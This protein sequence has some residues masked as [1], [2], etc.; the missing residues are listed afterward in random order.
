MQGVAILPGPLQRLGMREPWRT[1]ADLSDKR[2]GA[3]A[4]IGGAAL[5]AL[6]PHPVAVASGGDLSPVDGHVQHLA[7]FLGNCYAR[8][9]PMWP[10]IRFAR[11]RWSSSPAR[12]H[13][14]GCPKATGRRWP[15]AGRLG[16]R[17]VLEQIRDGE[18]SARPQLCRQGIRFFQA[19]V[20][21]LR[22]AVEPVYTEMR[23]DA[24]AARV[25][26]AVEKL[27]SRKRVEPRSCPAEDRPAVG[28]PS[29]TYAWTITRAEALRVR[30]EEHDRDFLA[31]LPTRSGR[32]SDEV[33]SSSM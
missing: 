13:G 10:R 33:T 11:D 3:P 22:R 16:V 25:L 12:R 31:Q 15:K 5:K 28:L 20:A 8:T 21:D 19:D 17:S 27:R 2:I 30:G 1:A 6:G 14:S 29:G 7:A 4:G 9:I 26:D 24:A 18:R 23:S 32:S